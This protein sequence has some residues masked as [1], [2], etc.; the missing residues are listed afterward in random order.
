MRKQSVD[1]SPEERGKENLPRLR[2]EKKENLLTVI[3]S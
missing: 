1:E 3:R 2:S